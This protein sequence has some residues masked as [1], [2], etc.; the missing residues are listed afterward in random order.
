M[1]RVQDVAGTTR[2]HVTS[3][4]PVMETSHPYE[5][6]TLHVILVLTGLLLLLNGVNKVLDKMLYCGLVGQVFVG[7]L[8]GTPGAKLL[9]D[10]VESTISNLGYLGLILLVYEGNV[11]SVPMNF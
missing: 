11:S 3:C 4:V 7:V 1:V 5:E 10:D 6:P 8:F 2:G 9:N